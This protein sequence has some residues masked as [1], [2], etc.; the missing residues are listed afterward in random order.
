MIL[1]CS[2]FT[3]YYSEDV[4]YSKAQLE[5]MN[6]DGITILYYLQTIVPGFWSHLK[7]LFVE[8]SYY[9]DMTYVGNVFYLSFFLQ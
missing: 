6:V 3:P 8:S 2:V 5:D 7:S 1:L 4:M 9:T